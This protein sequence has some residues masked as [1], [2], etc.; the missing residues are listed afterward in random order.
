MPPR[1]NHRWSPAIAAHELS[2]R[3]VGKRPAIDEIGPPPLFAGVDRDIDG[4]V[5]LH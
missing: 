3:R 5:V 1:R 2:E 4:L